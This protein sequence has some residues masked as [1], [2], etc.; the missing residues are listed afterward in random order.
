ME[1]I[2]PLGIFEKYFQPKHNLSRA[3]YWYKN[4]GNNNKQ[5][6]NET[7]GGRSMVWNKPSHN[8]LV[9][10]ADGFVEVSGDVPVVSADVVVGVPS[11]V[12]VTWYS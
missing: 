4:K 12:S 10:T 1:I 9:H 11:A 3:F 8:L 7:S 2:L 6:N 5:T